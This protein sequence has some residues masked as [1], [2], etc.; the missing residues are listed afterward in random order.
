ME[1]NDQMAA[2]L[3]ETRKY[4]A[5]YNTL[6]ETRQLLES[7]ATLIQSINDNFQKA[8]K[9]K[10]Q[11][12]QFLKSCRSTI[13]KLQQKKKDQERTL[14]AI[15]DEVDTLAEQHQVIIDKQRRYFKAVRSFQEACD[16]NER[17]SNLLED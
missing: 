1:L 16:E 11:K 8:M 14:G 3:E 13:Q 12:E 4:F 6:N 5:K 10:S 17:L 9:N 15:K 2:N 7:E